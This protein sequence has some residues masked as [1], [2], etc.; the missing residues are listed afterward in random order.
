MSLIAVKRV[1]KKLNILHL[2]DTEGFPDRINFNR[3]LLLERLAL[4][5][6]KGLVINQIWA[7]L[8]KHFED[9]LDFLILVTNVMGVTSDDRLVITN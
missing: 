4:A 9:I 3:E 5:L 8:D 6:F 2:F 1:Y 7:L